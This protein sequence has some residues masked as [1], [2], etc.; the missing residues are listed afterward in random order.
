MFRDSSDQS[1]I[2]AIVDWP[3]IA[4]TEAALDRG[5]R[6]LGG[7]DRFVK[8]GQY[9]LIKPNLVAGAPVE[10]G[11]TCHVEL[12]EALVQRVQ[13]LSPARVV[14]AEGA[15]VAD[16]A[17]TFALLGFSA[18][19]ERNGVEMIDLDHGEHVPCP[20]DDPVYPGVL[21]V[22]RPILECD[23][24]LSV[25]C[26][27]THVNAGIT[28]ALKNAYGTIAQDARTRIHREYRLEECLCDL[29]R[30]RRPDL[31]VV[32]GLVGAQGL[33]GGAD[34]TNPVGAKLLLAGDDPVAVDAIAARVMSQNPR[35]RYVDWAA[36][37]GVGTND[38]AAI[39]IVGKPL[40]E[41]TLDFQTPGEHLQS[42]M[43]NLTFEDRGSCTGCRT[44]AEAAL[45]RYRGMKLARPLR[46][47][48]GGG[49]APGDVSA[50]DGGEIVTVG[51]CTRNLTGASCHL[52][53]CPLRPDGLHSFIRE[54]GLACERCHEPLRE[55]LAEIG[56]DGDPVRLDDLR[57]LCAGEL[58]HQGTNNRARPTDL[59]LLVG[60]CMAHYYVNSRLRADQVLGGS[61]D[62]VQLVRGCAPSV[63]DIRAAVESLRAFVRQRESGNV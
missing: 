18:M 38:P 25:G 12:V 59:A 55:V 32:D 58:V 16:P 10:S 5:L 2:V 3:S 56:G 45:T 51:D 30:I 63:S 13:A 8:P 33:A 60:D 41:A 9:V 42:S 37:K 47:V 62:N 14:I 4:E 35:I 23:V 7:L 15:A 61:G 24:Y 11:G 1:A 29:N 44:I 21:E 31:V 39:R 53:G 50:N 54:A 17:R 49:G 52:P 27:K 34:F 40:A 6:L 57:A 28:A 20:V 43:E 46:I 48:F 19:A 26:L 36:A 22:A